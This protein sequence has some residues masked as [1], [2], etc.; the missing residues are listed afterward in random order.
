[1]VKIEERKI[2]SWSEIPTRKEELESIL[3]D[4]LVANINKSK[5][6]AERLENLGTVIG[7]T[8]LGVGIFGGPMA[9]GGLALLGIYESLGGNIN[10]LPKFSI[11][12][13][14]NFL[15]YSILFFGGGITLGCSL[16][17]TGDGYIKNRISKYPEKEEL[18]KEYLSE[19]GFKLIKY[20]WE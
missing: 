14:S 9:V 13:I 5:R 16:N 20:K 19:S 4:E 3:G 12:Q 10:F 8:T 6:K 18:I 1:M 2:R 15:D 11:N 7:A 17:W